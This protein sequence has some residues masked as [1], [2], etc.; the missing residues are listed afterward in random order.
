MTQKSVF[1]EGKY[2]GLSVFQV[3]SLNRQYLAYCYFRYEGISFTK[4][5]LEQLGITG[6]FIIPKPS[7]NIKK[8]EEWKKCD[9][10]DLID[11]Y[12][13]DGSTDFIAYIKASQLTKSRCK[14][15]LNRQLVKNHM[16]EK[17][18]SNKGVMQSINH[19]KGIND[20]ILL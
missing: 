6:N 12:K 1:Q 7:S 20:N 19:S 4:D 14:K 17:K 13:T 15:S 16:L 2:K 11:K 5:I 10:H 8:F 3:L 18:L 9:F